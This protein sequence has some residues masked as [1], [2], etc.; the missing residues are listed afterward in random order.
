ML[1]GS[2]E[3]RREGRS[4]V[5]PSRARRLSTSPPAILPVLL[6][7]V[8]V[9]L[10]TCAPPPAYTP[11]ET[12]APFDPAVH[13][14]LLALGAVDRQLEADPVRETVRLR[15]IAEL[16]LRL[17]NV[18]AAVGA[19]DAMVRIARVHRAAAIGTDEEAAAEAAY[20]DVQ[21]A[22]FA[23]A[24]GAGSGWLVFQA[25][26]DGADALPASVL[27]AALARGGS[28][29]RLPAWIV[30]AADEES[31]ARAEAAGILPDDVSGPDEPRLGTMGDL[32]RE[33]LERRMSIA[34]ELA[35]TAAPA[36][37]LLA[38][39]PRHLTA[40]A[41]SRLLAEADLPARA[42][43]LGA[44]EPWGDWDRH[45]AQLFLRY[46][47]RPSDATRLALAV[48]CLRLLPGDAYE[49]ARE[50]TETTADTAL[51]DAG[52]I[53]AALVSVSI[54]RRTEWEALVA[55]LPDVAR[56]PWVLRR[57][58]GLDV[59][60]GSPAG[61]TAGGWELARRPAAG[62]V[63]A[64]LRR[65]AARTLVELGS[66]ETVALE[67]VAADSAAPVELRRSALWRLYLRD[68]AAARVAGG[69][70]VDAIPQEDCEERLEVLR[71]LYD[72]ESGFETVEDV[73]RIAR[74]PV[75]DV[76]SWWAQTVLWV[77]DEARPAAREW[78]EQMAGTS[79]R[80]THD[81][82]A[83]RIRLALLD[84]DLPFARACLEADGELLS[85]A[86]RVVY[87]L[88]GDDLAAGIPVDPRDVEEAFGIGN[89][90]SFNL[91]ERRAATG[92]DEPT[93]GF[94]ARV[95][96]AARTDR[97]GAAAAAR[98]LLELSARLEGEE[99]VLLAAQAA[100][101]AREGADAA[102]ADAAV[103]RGSQDAPDSLAALLLDGPPT[104][105]ALRLVVLGPSYPW[106]LDAT[107]PTLA[108]PGV[109]LPVERIAR[110][111]GALTWPSRTAAVEE[112]L[113]RRT[114]VERR[115]SER[116]AQ[117]QR[118]GEA[119]PGAGDR[120]DARGHRSTSRPSPASRWQPS[121]P[122]TPSSWRAGACR[123]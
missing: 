118:G 55:R 35:E 25:A 27:R 26:W 64:D 104:E 66:E 105:V 19:G 94:V 50:L 5:V 37:V 44:A 24:D 42:G 70:M 18:D 54:G 43:L 91:T 34:D 81:V 68:P 31:L 40:L 8:G 96:D 2:S 1:Q 71:D 69:C 38:A 101:L 63:Q 113:P 10:L 16:Q 100:L 82:A 119:G 48:H 58:V 106:N 115:R 107:L 90:T 65:D 103:R 14:E 41:A 117:G 89:L 99:A 79:L 60:A 56:S 75:R 116:G 45:L 111:A 28:Y 102:T 97:D 23:I 6:V 85:P 67:A 32:G 73:G 9:F 52:D 80:S 4:L 13:A 29:A 36:A 57:L 95:A 88:W 20:R 109:E 114:A 93:G 123:I 86:E 76:T 110:I 3:S 46:Q 108:A 62:T 112:L 17:G 83:A 22:A 87:R 92:G 47:K 15:R 122:R 33:V 98:D 30:A 78:L 77:A 74:V 39:D 21:R 51:R 53:V 11:P 84:D 121:R 7:S 120:R 72:D 61:P 12:A 59:W 49:F